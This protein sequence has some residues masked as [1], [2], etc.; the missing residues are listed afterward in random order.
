M[1]GLH[2]KG[3]KK[4]DGR[5]EKWEMRRDYGKRRGEDGNMAPLTLA[6]CTYAFSII[7]YDLHYDV[8]ATATI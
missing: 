4:E 8:L 3:G 5:K 2:V 6:N 1:K 7:H